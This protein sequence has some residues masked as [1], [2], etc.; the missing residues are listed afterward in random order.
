MGTT[1][2]QQNLQKASGPSCQP[3]SKT[4]PQETEKSIMYNTAV[5]Q[6][7]GATKKQGT[8]TID[9]IHQYLTNFIERKS[10]V[11]FNSERKN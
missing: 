8:Y 9:T 1:M 6:N 4:H 10:F 3:R 7:I 2:F 11:K 5:G